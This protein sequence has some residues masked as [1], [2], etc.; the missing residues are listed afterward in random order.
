MDFLVGYKSNE[1]DE[2]EG[3]IASEVVFS[4]NGAKGK[5]GEKRVLPKF[6]AAGEDLDGVKES[7]VAKRAKLPKM[8]FQPE[9]GHV[10][11]FVGIEFDVPEELFQGAE[12]FI[13]KLDSDKEVHRIEHPHVSLSRPFL[14]NEHQFESFTSS[15]FNQFEGEAKFSISCTSWKVYLSENMSRRFASLVTSAGNPRILVLIKKLDPVITGFQQKPYYED[16]EPHVSLIWQLN[17]P[18]DPIPESFFPE[19][20]PKPYKF[21]AS[22]ISIRS[23]NKLRRVFLKD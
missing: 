11:T 22:S 19:K 9:T 20:L 7:K 1:D 13:R 3:K 4:R 18:P 8:L 6:G 23:G 15:V 16:P 12:S 10:L 2:K 21:E 5:R 17:E 14:L